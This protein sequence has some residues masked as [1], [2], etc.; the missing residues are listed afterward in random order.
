MSKK[1]GTAGK[2]IRSRNPAAT[3]ADLL[4]AARKLFSQQSYGLVGSRQIAAEAGVTQALVIRYFGSKK[5]LFTAAI[6][7]LF[8]PYQ[9]MEG[10]RRTA[11]LRMAAWIASKWPPDSGVNPLTLLIQ[12]SGNPEVN[13]ILKQ[14][15]ETQAIENLAAWLGG[16][17]ALERARVLADI[18]IGSNITYQILRNRALAKS[19]L[20]G[21][22]EILG[23]ILQRIVDESQEGEAA[24]DHSNTVKS[25]VSA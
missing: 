4:E 12:S 1:K 2:P 9:W 18:I 20:K 3:R 16:P 23:G 14:K 24:Q 13:D 25:D 22:I 15:F 10:D 17:R 11:G 8:V 19:E 7:G 5:A 21:V 6:D